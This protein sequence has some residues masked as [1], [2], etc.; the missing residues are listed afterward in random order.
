M[1]GILL[2]P[3]TGADL[4]KL[5]SLRYSDIFLPLTERTGLIC[6]GRATAGYCGRL[7]D[8]GAAEP[9][10]RQEESRT[11]LMEEK[12]AASPCPCECREWCLL[13]I[14]SGCGAHSPGGLTVRHPSVK[15]ETFELSVQAEEEH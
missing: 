7:S 12:I 2:V 4:F 3:S 10:A 15:G 9:S 8:H 11:T 14:G 1:L 6:K 5:L 13:L